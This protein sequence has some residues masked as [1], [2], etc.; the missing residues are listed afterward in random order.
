MT[1]LETLVV[2]CVIFSHPYAIFCCFYQLDKKRLVTDSDCN[3]YPWAI[4]R[5]ISP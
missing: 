5:I 3:N 4:V 1:L 2:I